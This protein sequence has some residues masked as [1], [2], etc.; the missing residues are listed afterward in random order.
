MADNKTKSTRA[1]PGTAKRSP[2]KKKSGKKKKKNGA[3]VLLI[4]IIVILFLA[5][6]GTL[7]LIFKPEVQKKLKDFGSQIFTTTDYE[8]YV[9]KHSSEYGIDPR[10]TFAI[11]NTESHFDP[12]ATSDVGARGLMQIMEDAYN[13]IKY[14]L[15]DKR[16][17]TFDD[18]YDPELNIQYG[19]YYLSYLYQRYGSYELTA[20]AYHAGMNAVDG[21]IEDGTVDPENPKSSDVPSDVTAHYIDKV[22]SAYNKYKDN[23]AIDSLEEEFKHG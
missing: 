1:K 22:M 8:E 5:I 19:S 11:I 15:D 20:A 4:I 10:F 13:W 12:K 18:M 14:R 21:W 2:Q 7:I 3:K 23:S 6:I 9:I 17:H 16:E